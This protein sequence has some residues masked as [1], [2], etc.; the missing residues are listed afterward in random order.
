M[1]ALFSSP[2]N[3]FSCLLNFAMTMAAVTMTCLTGKTTCAASGWAYDEDANA[4]IQIR[5]HAERKTSQASRHACFNHRGWDLPGSPVSIGDRYDYAEEKL[6]RTLIIRGK[7]F[8]SSEV[9][10]TPLGSS[11]HNFDNSP[12][13]PERYKPVGWVVWWCKRKLD[14]PTQVCDCRRGIW[15]SYRYTFPSRSDRTPW[16]HA[17]YQNH[18]RAFLCRLLVP[19]S[20]WKF[21]WCL[22]YRRS[23]PYFLLRTRALLRRHQQGNRASRWPDTGQNTIIRG[24][25]MSSIYEGTRKDLK[26]WRVRI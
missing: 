1:F 19:T 6:G 20:V 18:L 15:V 8:K 9:L 7:S 23:A 21:G 16:D 10:P 14:F 2:C 12:L 25:K 13:S 26:S 11:P 24:P 3:V 5:S 22:P 4:F 17:S